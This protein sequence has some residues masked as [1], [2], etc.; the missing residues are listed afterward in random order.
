MYCNVI[1]V[2]RQA[3]EDRSAGGEGHAAEPGGTGLDGSDRRR[4]VADHQLRGGVL[5]RDGVPLAAGGRGRRRAGNSLRRPRSDRKHRLQVPRG[6]A[7][8]GRRRTVLRVRSAGQSQRTCRYAALLTYLLT[9]S[10]FHVWAGLLQPRRLRPLS[11][12]IRHP[13]K[14]S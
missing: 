5:R 8:Q 7:E 9:F 1:C 10:M 13:Q 14:Y 4:R 3:R 2:R 11:G 6:R 12:P